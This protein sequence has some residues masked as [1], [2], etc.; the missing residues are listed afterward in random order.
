MTDFIK[1]I[2]I[3][4][5]NLLLGWGVGEALNAVEDGVESSRPDQGASA[6]RSSKAG[7]RCARSGL[8]KGVH[9]SLTALVGSA[10]PTGASGVVDVSCWVRP[11]RK[12]RDD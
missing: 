6:R 10:H 7:A 4:I 1:V 3:W 2:E 11:S 8:H 9:S 12:T 5:Q